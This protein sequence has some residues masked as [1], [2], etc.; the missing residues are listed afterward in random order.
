M[1]RLFKVLA[2]IVSITSFI[3]CYSTSEPMP[4]YLEEVTWEELADKSS[5]NTNDNRYVIFNIHLLGEDL[6]V[7]SAQEVYTNI[8]GIVLVNHIKVGT[9]NNGEAV[10]SLDSFLL[11]LPPGADTDALLENYEPGDIIKIIGRTEFVEAEFGKFRH[12]LIRVESF[13]NLSE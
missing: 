9:D 11:G 8:S 1:K 4:T 7:K 3:S 5:M 13:E 2:V 10:T 6:S 12:L